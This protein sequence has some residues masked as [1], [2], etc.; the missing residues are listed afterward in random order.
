MTTL[1]V[2][3][4]TFAVELVIVMIGHFHAALLAPSRRFRLNLDIK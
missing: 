2:L 1:A 4:S 3:T